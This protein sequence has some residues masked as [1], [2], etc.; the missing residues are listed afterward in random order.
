MVASR[1]VSAR[2]ITDAQ[3][4]SQVIRD[5]FF[6]KCVVLP[7]FL[8]FTARRSV[9]LPIWQQHIPYLGVYIV[10]EDMGPDGDANAGEIRFIHR[11]QI[12]F[13][14]I[15]ENNDPVAAELKLDQAFW[16]IMNGLWRDPDLMNF[17]N[18]DMPDNVRVEAVERGRRTHEWGSSG[19][20]NEK[21]SGELRYTATV[22]YRAEYGARV[23]DDF[24]HMHQ[25]TVPL[26]DDDTAPAVG[27]VQRIITEYEFTPAKEKND[28]GEP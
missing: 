27:E 26:K 17:I 16:A 7:F 12:G 28:D 19:L 18:S 13:Q 24:L 3:S 11:L 23:T 15:I 5:S 14:V 20:N 9:Q 2:G 1:T 4:Y 25:E 8:N 10:N 22:L 6:A 21:P